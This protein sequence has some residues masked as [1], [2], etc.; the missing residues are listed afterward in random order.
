VNRHEHVYVRLRGE[1]RVIDVGFGS[2][3]RS[4]FN[5]CCDAFAFLSLLL[6]FTVSFR[7]PALSVAAA[8]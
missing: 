1:R 6:E 2:F 7:L 3:F 4:G 8:L 5:G